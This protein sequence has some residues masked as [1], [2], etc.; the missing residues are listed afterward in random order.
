MQSAASALNGQVMIIGSAFMNVKIQSFCNELAGK[1]M[2]V[3][4][5]LVKNMA[6]D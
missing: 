6:Y 2:L 4:S 3:F 1:Y 5:S